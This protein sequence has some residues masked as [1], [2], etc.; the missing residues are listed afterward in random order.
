MPGGG[1]GDQVDSAQMPQWMQMQMQYM[2]QMQQYMQQCHQYAQ[3]TSVSMGRQWWIGIGCYTI[4]L[5][6]QLTLCVPAFFGRENVIFITYILKS[7]L[8]FK[9]ELLDTEFNF[10]VGKNFLSYWP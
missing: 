7:K 1:W 6:L 4:F 5:Q 3:V 2:Q 10:L 9:T 8:D